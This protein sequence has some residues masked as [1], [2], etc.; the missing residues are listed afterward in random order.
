VRGQLE[1]AL[2]HGGDILWTVGLSSFSNH[3]S[4]RDEVSGIFGCLY[5]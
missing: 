3:R 1:A 5:I 2:P 4:G